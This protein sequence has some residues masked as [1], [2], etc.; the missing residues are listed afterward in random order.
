MGLRLRKLKWAIVDHWKWLLLAL[1]V[2]VAVAYG[3]YRFAV[4]VYFTMGFHQ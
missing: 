2:V 3:G 4:A 1:A